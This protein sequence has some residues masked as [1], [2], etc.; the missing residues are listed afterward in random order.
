[1]QILMDCNWFACHLPGVLRLTWRS[2]QT[3]AFQDA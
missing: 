1:M 3:V 2:P